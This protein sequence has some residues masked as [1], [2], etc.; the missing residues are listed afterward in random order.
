MLF[1]SIQS[2]WAND[3]AA[4]QVGNLPSDSGET[5]TEQE[6]PNPELGFGNDYQQCVGS[7]L[8]KPQITE[9][10]YLPRKLDLWVA[11]WSLQSGV[12]GY[13]PG[14]LRGEPVGG[15]PAASRAW[16]DGWPLLTNRSAVSSSLSHCSGDN[17]MRSIW[18]A[19]YAVKSAVV[20]GLG[21]TDSGDYG[22]YV[23]L[24]H[25]KEPGSPVTFYAHLASIEEGLEVGSRVGEGRRIAKMGS[26]GRGA[27]RRVHLHLSY[28][29]NIE[30]ILDE[31]GKPARM[32]ILYRKAQNPVYFIAEGSYPTNTYIGNYHSSVYEPSFFNQLYRRF[33]RYHEGIDFSGNP[34]ELIKDWQNGLSGG[35]VVEQYRSRAD[36]ERNPWLYELNRR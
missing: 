30:R 7:L 25:D 2:L 28:F 18:N 24:S 14:T 11:P 32:G 1:L 13:Q 8:D 34:T 16:V 36:K 35:A 17:Q 31:D 10:P 29:S 9:N 27:S 22:R 19:V 21:K 23:L 5:Q 4:N 33:R 20:I 12:M 6:P 3:A 15:V 26:S